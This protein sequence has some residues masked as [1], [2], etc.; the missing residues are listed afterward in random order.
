MH[1]IINLIMKLLLVAKNNIILIACNR[2][3]KIAY[4]MT[5]TEDVRSTV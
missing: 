1:L 3:S 2:L 4:F 5:M